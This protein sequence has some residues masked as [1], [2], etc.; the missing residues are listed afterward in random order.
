VD[1]RV[2]DVVMAVRDEERD[3]VVLRIGKRLP[4]TRWGRRLLA[5]SALGL[6]FP[7]LGWAPQNP[8]VATTATIGGDPLASLRPHHVVLCVKDRAAATSW[9]HEKLGFADVGGGYVE[10]D[11]C[12]IRLIESGAIAARGSVA[13]EVDDTGSAATALQD[14]GVCVNY[15]GTIEAKAFSVADPDGNIVQFVQRD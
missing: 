14:R 9:Y 15:E 5:L 12:R 1:E 13:F 8:A 7:V 10:R 6:V 11:G 2:G 4:V 3:M